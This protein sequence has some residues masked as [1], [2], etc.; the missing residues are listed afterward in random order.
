[1][2]KD[3]TAAL[4]DLTEQARGQTSR[5]DTT[6]PSGVPVSAI[7]ERIGTALPFGQTSGG[8]ASPLTEYDYSLRTFFA[9]RNVTDSSGIL[10][11]KIKP[12]KVMKFKDANLAI[13]EFKFADPT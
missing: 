3:L 8:I 4:H 9:E 5:S 13:V 7:P 10:I 11:F 1:M 12:I 6:L 2:A